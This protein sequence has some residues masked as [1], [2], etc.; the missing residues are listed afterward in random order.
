[1]SV[2]QNVPVS[3]EAIVSGEVQKDHELAITEKD[4]VLTSSQE[5]MDDL[6]TFVNEKLQFMMEKG[7][8]QL[9]GDESVMWRRYLVEI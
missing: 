5:D 9:F 1:M 8:E 2:L 6:N 7:L 3:S 4:C